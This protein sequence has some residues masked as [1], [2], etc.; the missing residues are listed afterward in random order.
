MSDLHI[1]NLHKEYKGVPVLNGIELH[2]AQGELVSLLGPSGCGKSTTLNI[3]AGF[4]QPTRG[5]VLIGGSDVTPEPPY[6]RDSSIVFQNYA[7]FPHKTVWANVAFGLLRRKITKAEIAKRVGEVL[8]MVDV[9]DL[10][11][12]YPNQLSGGQQQRVAVARAIAVQPGV[13]LLDEPLSNIDQKLRLEVR[14]QLRKL[15]LA[16]K[17]TALFVTHDQHEAIEMSDR[18]AVMREGRIEQLGTPREIFE[19]P[20]TAYV[21]DFVGFENLHPTER[22]VSEFG[23]RSALSHSQSIAFR[24]RNVTISRQRVDNPDTVEIDARVTSSTYV[25]DSHRVELSGQSTGLPI[26]AEV[27][28]D[29]P[30]LRAG[31]DVRVALRIEDLVGIK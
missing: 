10:A 5:R 9:E 2:V 29:S 7:L 4:M 15:Q 3:V 11:S 24:A 19:M 28:G 25:G 16:L 14:S 26:V 13:L 20:A 27:Q 18:I 21:A 23:P 8:R 1:E 17:Q 31:D 22:L 6:R 12:R 30:E